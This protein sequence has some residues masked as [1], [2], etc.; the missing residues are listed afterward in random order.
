MSSGHEQA[1]NF[2]GERADKM[3]RCK[4]VWNTGATVTWSSDST[5]FGE[6][7]PWNPMLGFEVG[8]TKE[9]TPETNIKEIEIF[10]KYP[11]ASEAMNV[12]EMILGYTINVAKQLGLE[13]RKGSIEAGKDAD[14]LIFDED[15]FNVDQSG[16]SHISPREVYFNGIRMN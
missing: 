7:L 2:L 16:F 4:S 14:Y 9:M 13:D 8:I 1:V 6:F 3:Y 11:S 5:Q 12:E 10:E 15:L